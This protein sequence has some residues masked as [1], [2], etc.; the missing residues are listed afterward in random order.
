MKKGIL[1][2]LVLTCSLI[3]G[4]S[5]NASSIGYEIKPGKIVFTTNTNTG[6]MWLSTA[7][8]SADRKDPKYEIFPLSTGT[9]TT[10]L[11]IPQD[12]KGGTFEA[13]IWSKKV[14]KD[15]C[16]ETDTICQNLG[17]KLLDM[18][19]YVWGYIENK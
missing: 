10:E 2:F 13:G 19:S 3:F 8:Y 5:A 16:T 1:L 4:P 14:G 6:G 12:K 18:R 9:K 11:A 17:Y 7:L 15:K